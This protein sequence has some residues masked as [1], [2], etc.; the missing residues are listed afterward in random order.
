MARGHGI[1]IKGEDCQPCGRGFESRRQKLDGIKPKPVVT[2]KKIKQIKAAK[3]IFK[4]KLNIRT[5]QS[6]TV[7]LYSKI[8]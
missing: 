1:V 2:L 7:T 8:L 6:K 5:S 3:F 4:N